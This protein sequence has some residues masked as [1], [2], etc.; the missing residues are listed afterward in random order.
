M[1]R[2]TIS[3]ALRAHDAESKFQSRITPSMLADASDFPSGLKA[4]RQTQFV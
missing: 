4:T 3:H 2:P 1:F